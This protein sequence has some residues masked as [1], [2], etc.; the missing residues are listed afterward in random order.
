[1]QKKTIIFFTLLISLLLCAFVSFANDAS[2]A[3]AISVVADSAGNP[4]DLPENAYDAKNNAVHISIDTGSGKQEMGIL[5]VFSSAYSADSLSDSTPLLYADY[6]STGSDGQV[7]ADVYLPDSFTYGS[8]TVYFNST[9]L[10][11]SPLTASF[12]YY[13]ENEITEELKKP[14]ILEAVKSASN[15]QVLKSVVLGTKLSD[16]AVVENDNFDIIAPVTTYYNQLNTKDKAFINM[17]ANLSK[18]TSFNDIA[19]QFASAAQAAYNAEQDKNSSSGTG[20][21][22]GGGISS[23]VMSETPDPAQQSAGSSSAA[24]SFA[25]MTGHWAE[26][27][28]ASL[29]AQGV[30]NGYEDGTFRP[31][32]PVTR[33]ELAKIIVGAFDVSVSGGS[34]FA[35]VSDSA[36]YAP[37]VST[38]AAAGIVTGFED[39]SFK[40]DAYVTRQDAAVMIYRAISLTHQMP[41][42]F[43]FFADEID[44]ADYSSSAVKALAD[45]KIINGDADGNFLPSNST[46]RAETAALI[47]RAADY[48]AAH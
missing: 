34:A 7:I 4:V 18:I 17:Y 14:R 16:D 46:T 31:S 22:G 36:W 2:A 48:V 45:A 5:Y 39:G 15:W 30:V 33:A 10:G 37:Y 6:L 1:M 20:S 42:G 13:T 9:A 8:Y 28:A 19:V 35:D 29:A 47:S 40:P 23:T 44:I 32:V 27:Y 38:A 41:N 26:E 12:R 24:T 43:K 21:K 3:P 25:D 11:G